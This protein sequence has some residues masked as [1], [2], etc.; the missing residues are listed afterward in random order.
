MPEEQKIFKIFLQFNIVWPFH[1][2]LNFIQY[3][4]RF[5]RQFIHKTKEIAFAFLSSLNFTSNSFFSKLYSRT[6]LSW[7]WDNSWYFALNF[8]ALI[9]SSWL[10]KVVLV[11]ASF[12]VL[13]LDF[14]K[15][16]VLYDKLKPIDV[17]YPMNPFVF[18]DFF[19]I[20]GFHDHILWNFVGFVKMVVQM[21][22][23]DN[24]C[25]QN[26]KHNNHREKLTNNVVNNHPILL[27]FNAVFSADWL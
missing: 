19:V 20:I 11:P 4:T 8:A 7:L 17:L 26:E 12:L 22:Q 5:N 16:Y 15:G 21:K 25:C 27:R 6:K 23:N 10:W 14:C 13:K 18:C 2:H 9:S 1:L 24:C 3:S